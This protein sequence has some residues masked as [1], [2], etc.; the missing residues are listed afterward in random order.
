[1]DDITKSPEPAPGPRRSWLRRAL[2]PVG[3]GRPNDAPTTPAQRR[4]AFQILFLSLMCLGIGQ[5]GMFAVLPPIS[6]QLGL[7]EFQ[8]GAIFA[9]SAT[10]WV[11]SSAYWGA[12]SDRW[13]RRPMIVLGLAAFAVS[14]GF[15]A[16]SIDLGLAGWLSI[17]VVY[18][19]MVASRSIY[20]IFGSAGFPAAQGYIADRTAPAE[21]TNALANLNAAFGLGTTA[22]PGVIAALAVLG[23]VA[24]FYFV[25]ALGGISAFVIWRFLPERTAPILKER[26]RSGR[27]GTAW[28]DPGLLL[29]VTAGLIGLMVLFGARPLT[30]G[31]I[32]AVGI[33]L[34]GLAWI[35]R[36]RRGAAAEAGP[37]PLHLSWRDP[38]ILPFIVF[39]VLMGTAGS[40][41]IQVIAFFFMDVVKADEAM[42]VQLAGVGLMTSSMAA[43]FAQFVV[44]QRFGLSAGQ[45]V[46][47][48]IATAFVSYLTFIIGETYGL[49]IFALLLSGLG[50]G[51]I[52]PGYAAAVSLAVGADQQG[53]AAGLTGGAGASGFIFAPLIG[54]K[55]YEWDP[56]APFWLGAAL[57]IAMAIYVLLTPRLRSTDAELQ[58]HADPGVPKV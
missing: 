38:R 17:A 4:R 18:P 2:T 46:L 58:E 5:A 3:A 48:G 20:G 37:D 13:G 57:M 29:M 16:V 43:L 47:W 6:R 23:T 32:G 8:T 1:M 19:M 25:A 33:V 54:N 51:L 44:V 49:I 36:R 21:R 52:R 31:T 27:D 50:F 40:I 11:F 10:I 28:R 7:S 26:E 15:F 53:A 55:L 24:P 56:H 30:Y 35:A 12:R 41:P 42:A 22:G 39:G 34:T 9:V 45:L 14:T